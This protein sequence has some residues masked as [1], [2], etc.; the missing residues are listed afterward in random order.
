M[1][2][3]ESNQLSRVA[4]TLHIYFWRKSKAAI[5]L[6]LEGNWLYAQHL[7]EFYE[8]GHYSGTKLAGEESSKTPEWNA[9]N[10]LVSKKFCS[11]SQLLYFSG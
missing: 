11:G 8:N 3:Y 10:T 4:Y 9:S 5:G 2:Y 6:D 7:T 1:V